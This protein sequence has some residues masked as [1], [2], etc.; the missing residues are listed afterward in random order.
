MIKKFKAI[1]EHNM[2]IGTAIKSF[3]DAGY[4]IKEIYVT[5]HLYS[6]DIEVGVYNPTEL[7]DCV[8]PVCGV[9]EYNTCG[10]M[11]ITSCTDLSA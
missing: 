9:V 8:S 3:I 2:Q 5:E 7:L 6:G 11:Y 1:D 10:I 4:T